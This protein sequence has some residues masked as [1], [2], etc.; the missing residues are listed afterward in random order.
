MIS[1]SLQPCEQF[2]TQNMEFQFISRINVRG[3]WLPDVNG[4]CIPYH[5]MDDKFDFQIHSIQFH[6]H[7]RY[8][9]SM[10]ASIIVT[11]RGNP[12]RCTMGIYGRL[13]CKS[14]D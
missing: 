2:Y 1:D 11:D 13:L 8:L 10:I 5:K 14:I 9:C 6:V 12:V 7:W 3:D 4:E